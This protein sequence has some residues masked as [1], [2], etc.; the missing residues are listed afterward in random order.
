[1]SKFLRIGQYREGNNNKEG[2]GQAFRPG[3]TSARLPMRGIFAESEKII[4]ITTTASIITMADTRFSWSCV[5][6]IMEVRWAVSQKCTWVSSIKSLS[7]S[8]KQIVS[9]ILSLGLTEE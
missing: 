7:Y 6:A 9:S 2:E 3:R 5:L 4:I 1:M 8:E